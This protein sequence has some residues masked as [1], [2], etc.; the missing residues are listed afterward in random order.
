MNYTAQINE[1]KR[2]VTVRLSDGSIGIARC[3][4][5]DK[6]D[7]HTGIELALER[8]KNATKSKPQTVIELVKA[9]EKALPEGEMVVVGNGKQMNEAQKAWLR[10]LVGC[11]CRKV[12]DEE[13]EAAYNEGMHAGYRDGYEEGYD[14]GF[15]TGY[16]NAADCCE[17]CHSDTDA[18]RLRE[19]IRKVFDLLSD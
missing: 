18:E 7:T 4:P 13:L 16:D 9:L 3:N 19:V 10:S 8:A 1:A 12:N 14:K 2:T 17:E 6:W 5:T 15:N 11:E